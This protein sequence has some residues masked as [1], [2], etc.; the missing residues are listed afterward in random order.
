MNVQEALRTPAARKERRTSLLLAAGMIL[1]GSSAEPLYRAFNGPLLTVRLLWCAIL[2]VVGL[3]L[4]RASNRQC[5][6]LLPIAGLSSSWL[7]AITVWLGGGIA[8]PDFPYM[9]LIPLAMMVLFQDEVMACAASVVAAISGVA[10]LMWL[11]GA[12]ISVAA[13]HLSTDATVGVLALFGAFS[14]RRVRIAELRT[15]RARTEALE[16]LA[17]SEHRR[18]QAERLASLGQLAAGVAHEINNPLLAVSANVDLLAAEP[19]GAGLDPAEAQAA[20]DDVRLGIQRIA[21][22][23]RDLRDYARGGSDELQPCQVDEVIGDALRLASF[24]LGKAIE[25]RRHCE[26]DLPAVLIHRRKLSQVLLN[27]LV[28]AAEAVE[29]AR[30]RGPWVRVAAARA[31]GSVEIVIEDNG[32]GIAAT[33]ASRLFEP[34]VTSKPA[35]KGTGLGLALSREYVTSFGGTLELRPPRGA[36]ARFAIVLPA[37]LD[38]T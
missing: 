19:G 15:Q 36:G 1:V 37:A 3:T 38:A 33:V 18:A 35:G 6:V 20:L 27:L 16:Q 24:K 9:L 22:I 26:P 25:V 13:D 14:F 17:M 31:G 5:G 12:P 4:P 8:S 29:E 11:S 32:P 10:V 34:F 7:F 21:Q 28:N 2:A 23:V 30:T